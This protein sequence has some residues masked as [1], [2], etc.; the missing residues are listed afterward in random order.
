MSLTAEQWSTQLLSPRP[1]AADDFSHGLRR[2]V[3]DVA[4]RKV[5]VQRN[6]RNLVGSLVFDVDHDD[7]DLFVKSLM[8][9]R[10]V[11]PEPS[12]VT[13]NR[14]S[15]HAHVGYALR[16]PVNLAGVG[17]SAREH[18]AKYCAAVER[19]LRAR[20]TADLD[21]N[22]L[23]TRNPLHPSHAVLWGPEDPYT[24][25]ELHKA[26]GEL[27]KV[28]RPPSP[29]VE[30]AVGR[31]VALFDAVRKRAYRMHH[32]YDTAAEFEAAVMDVAV[33]MNGEHFDTPLPLREVRCSVRSI[34]KW[35][36]T[37]FDREQFSAMQRNRV[38]QTKRAV[39]RQAAVRHVKAMHDLGKP[40]S[41]EDIMGIFDVGRTTAFAYLKEAGLTETQGVGDRPEQVAA[42]RAEGL[43]W[44]QVMERTGL[45]KTQARYAYRK[46]EESQQG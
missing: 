31:N 1:Y 45:S 28:S 3:P 22:G 20:L 26:L 35:T 5:H 13:V 25:A 42:L 44:A 17:S 46:W 7:A 4:L 38:M 18:P 23:T 30:G 21:Y 41:I 34:A 9:D 36:W 29:S 19:T 10:E 37:T 33:A 11:I 14:S 43:S 16:D 32:R 39:R 2:Y 27:D 12:W 8:W 40:M 15:G 24:L 6:S